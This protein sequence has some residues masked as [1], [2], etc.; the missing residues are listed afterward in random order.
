[1]KKL[2][3]LAL[4]T[5]FCLAGSAAMADD[6]YR[7]YNGGA[8]QGFGANLNTVQAVKSD[9][10][11]DQYVTLRGRLVDYLGH[12]H[13]EFAD[14]TGTIEVELDDDYNWSYISKGELI[15]ITGKVDKEFFSTTID[16]KR[17]VSLEKGPAAQPQGPRGP[18]GMQG[19]VPR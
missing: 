3:V 6:W 19:P 17:A 4:T 11:D 14:N 12:D 1:M 2:S 15:E 13:Y 8:P 16:V 10:R 5:V 7:D 9:A 18:Q